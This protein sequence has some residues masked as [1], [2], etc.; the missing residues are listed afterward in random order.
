MAAKKLRFNKSAFFIQD[1]L[2]WF[3]ILAFF[4]TVIYRINGAVLRWYIFLG[5]L[6][7]AMLYILILRATTLKVSSGLIDLIFKVLRK[8][9]KILVFPVKKILPVFKPIAK[10]VQN[11]RKKIHNFVQKNI[12]KVRRINILLKKI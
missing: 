12:E 3:I 4:F 8:T 1:I 2:I 10:Y 9:L 5:A 11:A 6:F 7:G